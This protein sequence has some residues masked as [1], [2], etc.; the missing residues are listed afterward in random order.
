MERSASDQ[1]LAHMSSNSLYRNLQ[2]AYM[3][4][5]STETALVKVKNDILMNMDKGHMTM[6]L[7][8]DLRL[9]FDTVDHN[10][11]LLSLFSRFGV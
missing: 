4:N 1:L 9:V 10:T 11:L 2:S 3:K 7:L 8:L 6:L 5:H